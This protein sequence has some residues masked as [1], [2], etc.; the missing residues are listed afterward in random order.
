MANDRA[1]SRIGW[2]K[3]IRIGPEGLQITNNAAYPTNADVLPGRLCVI[4]GKLHVRNPADTA[5]INL[6][7]SGLSAAYAAK[8]GNYTLAVTDFC[9]GGTGG[10]GGITLLLPAVATTATGTIFAISKVDAGVGAVTV[11]G[12]AAETI[13]GAATQGLTTQYNE[14][15]IINTGAEWIS[16]S[17][18]IG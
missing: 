18:K 9:I 4:D 10:A 5:W 17:K 13:D 16:L 6:V 7:A 12:N 11:D 3:G 14:I 8:D 2:R 1:I 15:V